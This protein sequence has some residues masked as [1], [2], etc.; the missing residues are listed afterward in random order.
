M[1][2]LQKNVLS[3]GEEGVPYDNIF[4][5]NAYLTQPIRSRCNNTIW[6]LAL[7]HGNFKQVLVC[8]CVLTYVC[9]RW[10][11]VD[12]KW[13]LLFIG[14]PYSDTAIDI[15][16]RLQCYSSIQTFSTFCRHTVRFILVR[17]LM[18]QEFIV[19]ISFLI[20]FQSYIPSIFCDFI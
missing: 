10:L 19:H 12:L 13:L 8:S 14:L 5:W 4:V 9:L 6:T 7:V 20:P 18:D 15:W 2:S 16:K 11:L 17:P 3:S 1:Q